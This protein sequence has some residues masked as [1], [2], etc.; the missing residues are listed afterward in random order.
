LSSDRIEFQCDT[1]GKRLRAPVNKAGVET[2]CP[3]C[4][5]PVQVPNA[6]RVRATNDDFLGAT[7]GP[8]EADCPVCGETVPPDAVSCPACGEFLG[9][10]PNESGGARRGGPTE[11]TL[12]SVW[13]SAVQDWKEH[14]GILLAGVL[15]AWLISTAVTFAL[16]FGMIIVMFGGIAAVGAGGGGGDAAGV[17]FIVLMGVGMVGF[18]AAMLAVSCW[19]LLGLAGMHLEAVRSRPDLGTLFRTIGFWRMLLCSTIVSV[20]AYVLA[21]L[22]MVGAMAVMEMNGGPGMGPGGGGGA[23]IAIILLIYG[24]WFAV[25]GLF[26]VLFWPVPFYCLDRPDV[27]HV[28]PIWRSLTMPSGSWG[29]HLAVGAAAYGLLLI[30]ALTC[31]VGLLFTGPLAGLLIAHTYDRFDRAETEAR[32][33]RRLDPEGVI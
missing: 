28:K 2:S 19:M 24:I 26:F 5:D 1:C 17:L 20:F 21:I 10:M 6:P 30:G 18:A 11:V 33:P 7:D 3:Q 9:A 13:Y 12:G 15:I 32:G 23:E 4:G 29:G 31:G 27:R 14:F 16:Y 22:P 25:Y 8:D